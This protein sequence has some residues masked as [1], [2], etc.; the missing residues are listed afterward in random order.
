MSNLPPPTTPLLPSDKTLWNVSQMLSRVPKTLFGN[1]Q[2]EPEIH[3]LSL[4][5]SSSPDD[6]KILCASNADARLQIL[7]KFHDHD[8]PD[9]GKTPEI[10]LD[11]HDAPEI[12]LTTT[13]NVSGRP[14][15]P[16]TLLSAKDY[17]ISGAHHK[18]RSVLIRLLYIHSCLHPLNRSPHIPSLL[19]PLYSVLLQETEPKDSAHIEADTFWVFQAMI[20]EF[21]ELEEEEG[22]QIWMSK[23]SERLAW[24]DEELSVSLVR[25]AFQNYPLLLRRF[26]AFK[27]P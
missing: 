13:E 15:V 8:E 4:L 9:S 21:S 5:D 6:I 3:P 12:S 11:S 19:I 1:L 20:A 16:M 18:H 14:R 10:R 2:D 25:F 22:G 27:R 24:A 17:A 26:A 7:Q 23:L